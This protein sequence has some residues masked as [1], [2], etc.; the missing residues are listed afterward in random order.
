MEIPNARMSRVFVGEGIVFQQVL[1]GQL[2]TN[3]LMNKTVSLPYKYTD[4]QKY[5]K[6]NLRLN[7]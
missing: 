1:L 5:L 4:I 3:I 7:S 2:D 6:M